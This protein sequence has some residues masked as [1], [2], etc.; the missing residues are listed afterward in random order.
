MPPV[1]AI[2]LNGAN[3]PYDKP[4][5]LHPSALEDTTDQAARPL[6]TCW[7]EIVRDSQLA[8]DGQLLPA[9]PRRPG[10]SA[11]PDAVPSLTASDAESLNGL[12]RHEGHSQHDPQLPK[13]NGEASLPGPRP[14]ASQHCPPEPEHVAAYLAERF[15][16]LGHKP[17]TLRV[18]AAAI[19]YVHNNCELE[20]PLQPSERQTNPAGGDPCG[21]QGSEAGEGPHGGCARRPSKPPPA[22]PRLG[23][24]GRRESAQA[25][26]RR[27]R[28]RHRSREAHCAT[29]CC[30]CPN[31]L[32]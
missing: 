1:E 23:K 22:V 25:A 31:A 18:A 17:A 20:K 32:R 3:G 21:R 7:Q 10:H 29:R 9:S 26:A 6:S 24:D 13:T 14:G 28:V 12:F 4:E 15:E 8:T 5:A 2:G 30:G 19:A 16:Q 11:A 27:G